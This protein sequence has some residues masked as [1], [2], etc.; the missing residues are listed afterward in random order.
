MKFKPA[1]KP[2]PHEGYQSENQEKHSFVAEISR[3]K[4]SF[5]QQKS[6]LA[7]TTK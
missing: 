4:D 1:L 7:D 6:I 3:V 5:N 2:G